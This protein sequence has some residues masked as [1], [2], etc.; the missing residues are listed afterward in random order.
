MSLQSISQTDTLVTL[1]EPVA[2]M[3][4]KDLIK[5]DGAIEEL[6]QTY[7]IIDFQQKQLG[8]YQQID[9]LKDYKINN[10]NTIILRKDEQFN[11]ER[12]KSKSLQKELKQKNTQNIFL[13]VGIGASIVAILINLVK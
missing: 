10:L 9:S 2:R 8:I 6:T 1:Q 12:E 5:G 7:R 4:I 11:L 3:V 13:K